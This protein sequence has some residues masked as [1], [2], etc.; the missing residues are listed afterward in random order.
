MI[1][2]SSTLW[3][4]DAI[5]NAAQ[6]LLKQQAGDNYVGFQSTLLGKN[7]KYK[8]VEREKPLLQIL[9]VD[10]NHWV[11]I[12]TL[13]CAQD[14]VRIFDS[15]GNDYISLNLKQQIC[16]LLQPQSD[17]LKFVKVATN[18]STMPTVTKYA[19][20][21][22]SKMIIPSRSIATISIPTTGTMSTI[23]A[24]HNSSP[25]TTPPRSIE[26]SCI[27]AIKPSSSITQWKFSQA[28][29]AQNIPLDVVSSSLNPICSQ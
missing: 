12:T 3:L 9:H 2:C 6:M 4:N 16:T 1:L 25:M 7:L 26:I 8:L 11:T 5:I 18:A 28:H 27:P 23:T 15:A 14:E 13:D 19:T 20:P 17:R 22:N 10:T 24:S 21:R 29:C